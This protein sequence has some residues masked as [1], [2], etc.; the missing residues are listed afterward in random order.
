MAAR[1]EDRKLTS[2]YL[3]RGYGTPKKL[4]TELL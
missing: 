4:E 3:V 2:V 1:L